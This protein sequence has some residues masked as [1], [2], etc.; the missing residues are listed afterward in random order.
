VFLLIASNIGSIDRKT[1]ERFR[2][3]ITQID[4]LLRPPVKWLCGLVKTGF[5]EA[6]TNSL[7]RKLKN[8]HPEVPSID[9]DGK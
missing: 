4:K 7:F 9:R 1:G 5:V 2:R 8:P 6:S 3:R